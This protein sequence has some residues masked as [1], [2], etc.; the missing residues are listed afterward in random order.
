[1]KKTNLVLVSAVVLLALAI[2]AAPLWATEY[3]V[4][5]T[6]NDENNGSSGS[7][8]LTI[9]HAV[10]T[11]LSGDVINV[12]G[13]TFDLTTTLVINQA[14]T[15]SGPET[16]DAAII[17]GSTL[18]TSTDVVSITANGVTLSHMDI[19][20]GLDNA[21]GADLIDI[22]GHDAKIEHCKIYGAHYKLIYL[23]DAEG[24][25]IDHCEI[26]DTGSNIIRIKGDNAGNQIQIKNSII[27]HGDGIYISDGGSNILIENNVLSGL[28]SWPH[29]PGGL[30]EQPFPWQNAQMG[31][32]ATGGGKNI[33]IKNNL[34]YAF[35]QAGIKLETDDCDI[36]GNTIAFC[37]DWKSS[38]YDPILLQ[39]QSDNAKYGF[40]IRIKTVTSAVI[41]NNIL[42]FNY[43]GI[44]IYPGYDGPDAASTIEYNNVFGGDTA[45]L[46]ALGMVQGVDWQYEYLGDVVAGYTWDLGLAAINTNWQ[47]DQAGNVNVDPK[48]VSLSLRDFHL[49]SSSPCIGAGDPDTDISDYEKDLDGN[50]RIRDAVIDMG[51]YEYQSG[52]I[53]IQNSIAENNTDI[54]EFTDAGTEL[55][56]TGTHNETIINAT[57]YNS[58]PGIVGNLP[59]GVEHIST[60][61]YWNLYSTEGNVGNY[62]VTFDLS[63]VSGIQ[64]FST[65]HILKRNNSSSSWQDV[66][67]D[68]GLTLTYN[69]PYITVNNLTAFSD[70]GIGG[71]SDNTLPVELQSF[72]SVYYTNESGNE[73]VSLNWSTASETDV[74]EFNIYRSKEANFNT[75]ELV[76]DEIIPGTN[77][78]TTHNY[79]YHDEKLF[80]EVVQEGDIYWYWLETIELGGNSYVYEEPSKLIIPE[81]YEQIIPPDLP[82]M[83]GLYQNFPNPFN[84]SLSNTKI[85][86]NLH[87]S[88]QVQINI[89]NI[90]GQ[91]VKCIYNDHAEFDDNNPRPKVAYWDGCDVNG[92]QQKSGIYFYRMIVNGNEE[93]IKKL[94]L[95]R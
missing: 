90:K 1:M 15:I 73:F 76:N 32:A 88:S 84:P 68:L 80:Y 34:I 44:G 31:I 8:W 11:V 69:N 24:T 27:Q 26:Y 66:V 45:G 10:N 29:N 56:F 51:A 92:K 79:T 28:H 60:D 55:Q 20:A 47:A 62:N 12:A 16:G 70:F 89:Y 58:D 9:Q 82:I 50:Y 36:I 83:Y 72:T 22:T 13:G 54:I 46:T 63:G 14:V 3:Y 52:G 59:T 30:D 25:I 91:L 61:R 6:G 94:L 42:A 87:N 43:R 95:I 53:T 37:Y 75:S 35:S 77:T 85:F 5:Q 4:S 33:V 74:L 64:N 71:G 17:N 65:L 49:Q 67:S 93:E 57:K 7:P 18:S 19:T 78:S 40:G 86:F 23:H 81:D 39:A 21:H 38:A 41:R 48:F 2:T